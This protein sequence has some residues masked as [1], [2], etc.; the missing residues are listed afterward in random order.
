M[1]RLL[2][3]MCTRWTTIK[4]LK[5]WFNDVKMTKAIE[6]VQSEIEENKPKRQINQS[7]T[8]GVLV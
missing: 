5:L 8:F 6:V 4:T 3:F 2:Y 1:Y 7:S